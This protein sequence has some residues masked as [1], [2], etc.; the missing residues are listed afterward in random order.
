MFMAETTAVSFW[1]VTSKGML[2][3]NVIVVAFGEPSEILE[4]LM[5]TGFF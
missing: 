2:F 1:S 5:H 3:L 4:G